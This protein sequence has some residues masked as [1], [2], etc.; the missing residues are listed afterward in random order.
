MARDRSGNDLDRFSLETD[1]AGHVHLVMVGY[2]A[3]AEINYDEPPKL[4]HLT[5]DGEAWSAP[6]MIMSNELYP[7]WPM[8]A[9]SSGNQ[10]HVV[11]YTR[12]KEDLFRSDKAHYRFWYSGKT[13]AAPAT[14]PL[15]LF[16]PTSAPLA[17]Q[18]PSPTPL[19]PTRTPL[20]PEVLNAP[21]PT[22][23]PAWELP[24][25]LTILLALLPVVGL[26]AIPGAIIWVRRRRRL[27]ARRQPGRSAW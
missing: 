10:L 3:A 1:S 7:E 21:A 2:P 27:A 22:S 20:P 26:F 5:W 15:P 11:W 4:M 24:G 17:T 6:D 16:T 12:S 8:I 9:V 19:P 13:V 25:V 14:T 23:G 18:A